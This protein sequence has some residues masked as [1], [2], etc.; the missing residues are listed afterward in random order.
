MSTIYGGLHQNSDVDRLYTPIKYGGRG[1]ITIEDSR[2]KFLHKQNRFLTPPLRRPIR[3]VLIL[4][5]FDNGCTAWFSNLSKIL[6]LRSS[7][8]KQVHQVLLTVR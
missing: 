2:L 5:L 4:P 1:L 8:T 3:N 6:K 7:V